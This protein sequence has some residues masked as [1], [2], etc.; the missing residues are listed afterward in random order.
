MSNL[1]NS[2]RQVIIKKMNILSVYYSIQGD[3]DMIISDSIAREKA[4]KSRI[5]DN[6][7]IKGCMLNRAKDQENIEINGAWVYRDETVASWIFKKYDTI[8]DAIRHAIKEINT[9]VICDGNIV[10]F[11]RLN[12][13]QAYYVDNRTNEVKVVE[14]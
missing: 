2:L 9:I 4:S 13:N 3:F 14:L 12:E 7:L 6:T 1:E 11:D 5:I 10:E 8:A